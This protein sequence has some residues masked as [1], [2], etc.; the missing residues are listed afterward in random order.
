MNDIVQRLT[1][2]KIKLD[3]E[4]TIES[5]SASWNL[6][7]CAPTGKMSKTTGEPTFSTDV[8]YHATLAQAC[9]F[10]LNERPKGSTSLTEILERLNQ[11]E[12][13]VIGACRGISK[14]DDLPTKAKKK[15]A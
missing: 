7:Y 14:T 12:R 6:H 5:D 11:A 8:S 3:D 9:S 4:Y 1:T 15:V 2:M 13:A 10:Y